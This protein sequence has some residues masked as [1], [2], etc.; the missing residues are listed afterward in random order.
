MI[1]LLLLTFSLI[2]FLSSPVD[3][4]QL[5]S[6]FEVF[7]ARYVILLSVILLSRILVQSM[8][9]FKDQ[10]FGDMAHPQCIFKEMSCKSEVVH[11]VMILSICTL[12]SSSNVMSNFIRQTISD[13][14]IVIDIIYV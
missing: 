5:F 8:N 14:P 6:E 3:A 7:V 2:I 4:E 10:Q 12:W 9:Q 1:T 13:S 11:R